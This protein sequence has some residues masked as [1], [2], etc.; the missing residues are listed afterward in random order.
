MHGPSKR[1]RFALAFGVNLIVA[2][3]ATN[4]LSSPFSHARSGNISQMLWSHVWLDS[5]AAFGLGYSIYR[6]FKPAAAKWVW[7]AG[8]CWVVQRAVRYYWEQRTYSVLAGGHSVFWEMSGLGCD[9]TVE[10]CRD[11]GL[12]TLQFLRTVFYSLGAICCSYGRT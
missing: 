2:C 8:L 11:F 9:S 5:L 4:I 3:V 10:S 7:I 1:V 12:Y 6:W